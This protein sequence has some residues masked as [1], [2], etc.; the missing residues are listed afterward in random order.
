MGSPDA[1]LFALRIGNG[2]F[3]IV[4]GWSPT[5]FAFSVGHYALRT[6][7]MYPGGSWT[8]VDG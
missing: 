3:Q 8:I 4:A 1:S 2:W 7:G 5:T 6:I